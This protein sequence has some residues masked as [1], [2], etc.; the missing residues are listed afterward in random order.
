MVCRHDDSASKPFVVKDPLKNVFFCPFLEFVNVIHFFHRAV[1]SL[2]NHGFKQIQQEPKSN[3][4]EVNRNSSRV[5][6]HDSFPIRLSCASGNVSQ[7]RQT[8]SR[9]SFPARIQSRHWKQVTPKNRFTQLF[10]KYGCEDCFFWM[11]CIWICRTQVLS[12]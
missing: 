4:S 9:Y 6:T 2:S 1:F 3:Q 5:K 11:K 10:G 7:N 12:K 8:S